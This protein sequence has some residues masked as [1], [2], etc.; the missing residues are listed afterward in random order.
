MTSPWESPLG[1]YIPAMMG[2]S[3]GAIAFFTLML[4]LNAQSP[5]YITL[6]LTIMTI[7]FSCMFAITAATIMIT[8][9][10][11]YQHTGIASALFFTARQIGSL[12]GVAIFAA[13][14]N[15]AP[16]LI[17]GIKYNL[18][19]AGILFF[20]AGFSIYRRIPAWPDSL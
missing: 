18:M 15:K 19:I 12:I 10:V 7:G 17:V 5:F 16:D 13:V 3:V 11:S 2:L 6:I 1:S 4:L 9:A 8:Q 14:I 20:I